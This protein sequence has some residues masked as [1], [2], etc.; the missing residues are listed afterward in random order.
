MFYQFGILIQCN[1]PFPGTRLRPDIQYRNF[2]GKLII[3]EID[4]YKHRR[5]KNEAQR[6]ELIFSKEPTA[7]ILHINVDGYTDT[8]S[9][10]KYP[11]IWTRPPATVNER[12]TIT[13]T[14]DT[15]ILE[16][17]RRYHVIK[18][19]LDSTMDP[20]CSIRSFRMFYE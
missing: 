8:R 5:Y 15:N 1:G 16:L 18:E 13:Q 14:T 7:I 12:G 2:H 10:I 19:V 17:H 4:E 20:N 6:N 11:A 9:K 3:L